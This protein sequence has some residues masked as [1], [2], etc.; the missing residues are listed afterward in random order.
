MSEESELPS[1][2]DQGAGAEALTQSEIDAL[3]GAS[4][5]PEQER[6]IDLLLQRAREGV[7]QDLPVLEIIA[8]RAARALE[9]KLRNFFGENVSAMFESQQ[10]VRLREFVNMIEVPSMIIIVRNVD[11]GGQA[12]LTLS[13]RLVYLA[14]DTLLGGKRSGS[15]IAVDGRQFTS[16]ERRL[17]TRFAN[18][19]LDV[20]REC[21]EEVVGPSRF[22]VDRIETIP[23]FAM[24][25]QPTQPCAVSKFRLD[26]ADRSG[27]VSFC[28]QLSSMYRFRETLGRL[29]F[30]DEGAA[31]EDAEA[32]RRH[33]LEVPLE[34]EAI[35]M[36]AEFDLETVMA[37]RPGSR[38][39]VPRGLN[40]VVDMVV[41]GRKVMHGK[42]GT[43]RGRLAVQL[44][45]FY[46]EPD[47]VRS[48]LGPILG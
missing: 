18:Q 41:G 3:F 35:L 26:I 22:A 8:D 45:D 32:V 47:P 28:L 38:I 17:M 42:I 5:T 23:R 6:A 46:S 13:S 14:V 39:E 4:N 37:W 20:M 44:E 36:E 10:S 33:T 19:F 11:W 24:I 21:W 48:R 25:G 12:L 43:K 27:I 15:E 2:E 31:P 29:S 40:A 7:M 30:R 16:V 1:T 34:A 9:T